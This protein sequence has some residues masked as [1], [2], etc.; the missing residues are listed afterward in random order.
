MA[1]YRKDDTK[2][3]ERWTI[4]IPDGQPA[5][6]TPEQRE[7]SAKFPEIS[8]DAL[9]AFLGQFQIADELDAFLRNSPLPQEPGDSYK[10]G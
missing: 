9:A 4:R 7:L 6:P 2:G 1:G 8:Q 5:D 10:K 3:D